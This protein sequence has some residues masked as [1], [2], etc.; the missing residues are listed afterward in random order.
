MGAGDPNSSF[1][2]CAAST[3]LTEPLPRPLNLLLKS[4]WWFLQQR[5]DALNQGRL[6]LTFGGL[7]E[8]HGALVLTQHAVM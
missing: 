6:K 8:R 7:A 2:A 4:G 5:Q 3:L 1:N